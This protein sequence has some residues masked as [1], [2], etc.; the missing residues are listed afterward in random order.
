MQVYG[1]DERFWTFHGLDPDQFNL[2]RNTAFISEGLARELGAELDDALLVRMER[3]SEVPLSS[4]HGRRDDV[5]RSLRLGIGRVLPPA[6]LGEFS[7]RPQQGLARSVFVPLARLQAELEQDGRVNT[8]LLRAAGAAETAA[9][10]AQVAAIEA[11][12]R[13]QATLDD[14]GLRVRA[15]PAQGALSVESAAGLL[16]AETEAA[17]GARRRHWGLA[18]EPVLTYLAT[19]SGAAGG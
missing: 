7:F 18:T 14:V 17:A 2:A 19:R 3:P 9:A 12:I 11:A 4:L 15:I 16:D 8:L 13:T 5:G 10:A 6:E 1:V